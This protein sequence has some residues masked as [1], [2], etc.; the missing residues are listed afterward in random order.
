MI[1]LGDPDL[2]QAI[3]CAIATAHNRPE[4]YAS[5]RDILKFCLG[6]AQTEDDK[7]E[8]GSA[9][10]NAAATA[11][12]PDLITF[13]LESGLYKPALAS[14]SVRVAPMRGNHLCMRA[15][16]QGGVKPHEGTQGFAYFLLRWVLPRCVLT[17]FLGF[18]LPAHGSLSLSSSP[19]QPPPP[20]LRA[21]APAFPSALFL[22]AFVFRP[23]AFPATDA[24]AL[25]EH[26][27]E[28]I[29]EAQGEPF[30]VSSRAHS[31]LG[32]GGCGC[33]IVSVHTHRFPHPLTLSL[34]LLILTTLSD[35]EPA[36][37]E[38]EEDKGDEVAVRV[39]RE[40]LEYLRTH[41]YPDPS[42][43]EKDEK[44]LALALNGAETEGKTALA[45][46]LRERFAG[47]KQT[48]V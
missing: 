35:G 29:R 33:A 6:L 32:M 46:L 3:G 40:Y 44:R 39:F 41:P 26:A 23:L 15:L 1:S 9:V 27:Q 47:R 36:E 21:P 11:D 20:P 42:V 7:A 37:V 4:R 13:V 43:R 5:A 12:H 48:G 34:P 2:R 17:P 24:S 28:L 30:S 38:G 10:L 45:Q 25:F 19:S 22:R 31:G 16:F 14:G 8:L 18:S